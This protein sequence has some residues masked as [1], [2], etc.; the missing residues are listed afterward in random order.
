[1]KEIWI[2]N[3]VT[4]EID[5]EYISQLFQKGNQL[6]KSIDGCCKV[7]LFVED[8]SEDSLINLVRKSDINSIICCKKSVWNTHEKAIALEQI[9]NCLYMRTLDWWRSV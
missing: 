9:T 8:K 5:L 2:V 6:A 4:S 3:S 1:M 7:V